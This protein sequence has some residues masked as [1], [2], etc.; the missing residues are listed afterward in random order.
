MKI[1]KPLLALPFILLLSCSEQAIKKMPVPEVNVVEAGVY[2]VPIYAE[3]VGQIYGEADITLRPRVEG[4]ITAIHFKEG[5]EVTKGEILY[6]I[7][8]VQLQN[9]VASAQA[10]LTEAEVRFQK[11]KSDLE[12]V[13]PLVAAS[14]LSQRDL[15]E[16]KANYQAQKENVNSAKAMKNNADTE[17]A[18][19]KIT[20]PIS[21]IIGISKVQ[22]GDYVSK[23]GVDNSINTISSTQKVKVR[24]AIT[25]NDYLNFRKKREIQGLNPT[26]IDIQLILSD[27]TLYPETGVVDFADRNID[28]LTG[29]L[30]I[31]AVF[32]NPKKTLRPGQ[33]AKIRFKSDDIKQAVIVPQQAINQLQN[34]YRIFVLNDSNQIQPRVIKVGARNGSNWVITEGLKP[35]ETVAVLGNAIVKPGMAIKPV[36][37]NWNYDST[38][39][40]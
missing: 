34:T 9:K 31:Q 38:L 20:A 40:K 28:P 8:D 29:T 13:E 27:G 39:V 5:N 10:N 19:A 22:V 7:E 15:D 36:Q 32:N 17:A 6:T 25:E 35:K 33:Y 26:Q 14:A 2:D 16:A 37:M 18:Y 23:V 24:F 11:A 1:T 3:Y 4:W 30:T 21:G 12:R